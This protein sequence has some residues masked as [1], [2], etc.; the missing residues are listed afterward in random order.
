MM[1]IHTCLL[2][3]SILLFPLAA[4]AAPKPDAQ[5]SLGDGQVLRGNF[6]EIREIKGSP[7]PFI[8]SGHF[9]VAPT[10]GLIWGVEKPMATAT[11]VTSNAMIQDVGGF[12]IK[13]PAKNLHHLFSM[14]GGAIRGDWTDLETDFVITPSGGD[15]WQ[16]TLTPRETNRTPYASIVVTGGSFVETIAMTR[17]DGTH[18]NFSFSNTVLNPAPLTAT[19]IT[20]FNKARQ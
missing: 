11:V 13:L 15:H 14:V 4:T 17:N 5:I 6:S 19:E 8:S 3:L 9:V 16:M 10:F 7:N 20:L 1:K 2:A 18:D 12:A